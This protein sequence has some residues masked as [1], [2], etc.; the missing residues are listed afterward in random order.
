MPESPDPLRG[1]ILRL[2]GHRVILNADLAHLY[3]TTTKRFNEAFKRNA[4]RFPSD[5]AFQLTLQEVAILR[6]QIATLRLEES[7]NEGVIK[8]WSQSGAT[9]KSPKRGHGRHTKYRP[10]V[11][12]EHGALMAANILNS[13]K[14][15]EMSIYVVRAFVKMR[16]GLA[17]NTTILKRLAE[18]DKTLI[19]QDT[20]LQVLWKKL[21]P[22][23]APPPETPKRRIG[24]VP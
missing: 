7:E 14:A 15:A 21:Q 18:I 1:R 23:L 8:M 4:A 9:S 5:F 16:E 13:D 10:W 20:A 22:L 24:F 11:F 17:T 12:S 6:S 2:R 19:E 3:G